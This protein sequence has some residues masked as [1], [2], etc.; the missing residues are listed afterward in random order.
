MA[1]GPSG[2]G[3]G[4]PG[5]RDPER[6]REGGVATR[7]RAEVARPSR[8]K[9]ILYNDDYTSMEFVVAVLEQIFG[10]GPAQAT[11]IM[12][13]IHKTGLGVAGVY[14]LEVAETKVAA[15][16]RAAE[17]RGYPLRAGAEKE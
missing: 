4:R 5:I 14:V 11:Q 15:V 17:E 2:P 10:K 16:H 8:F 1:N 7:E 12:L 9:V 3:G 6:E 13:Q